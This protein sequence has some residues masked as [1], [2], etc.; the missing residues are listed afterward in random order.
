MDYQAFTEYFN[1]NDVFSAKNGM[2]ILIMGEGYVEAELDYNPD[3][4]NFMGTL[5]GGSLST[6]ADIAAGVS[7]ISF[8]N[9]VVTLSSNINYVRP[10][11]PGKIKAVANAV[12]CSR[13]I[14]SSEVRIYD[15]DNSLV[16]F[17]SYI[18]FI[19]SKDASPMT[20]GNNTAE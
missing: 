15:E 10:A 11:K 19:T 18:M 7:I 13:Q 6:L 4:R 17:C 8:G 2:K 1:N 14:G 3:H 5:H 16:C 20:E 12:H 9:L